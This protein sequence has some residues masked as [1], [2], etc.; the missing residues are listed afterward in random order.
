V[1]LSDGR[2]L[3]ELIVKSGFANVLTIPPNV[4]Y[5]RKFHEALKYARENKLGLWAGK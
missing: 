4:K 1:Y 3:N 5:Q 2:F